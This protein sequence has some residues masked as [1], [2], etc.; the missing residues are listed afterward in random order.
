MLTYHLAWKSIQ[1]GWGR[2]SPHPTPLSTHN[3][4][5]CLRLEEVEPSSPGQC[6]GS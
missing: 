3:K 1:V 5:H 2:L 6:P 4:K